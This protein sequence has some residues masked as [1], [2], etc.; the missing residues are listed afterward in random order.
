MV[1]GVGALPRRHVQSLETMLV[2][3]QQRDA[4]SDDY[5]AYYAILSRPGCSAAKLV[6]DSLAAVWAG[7]MTAKVAGERELTYGVLAALARR[8]LSSRG[9]TSPANSPAPRRAWLR[10][11]LLLTTAPAMMAG[12]WVRGR[13]RAGLRRHGRR[14]AAGALHAVSPAPHDRV[15]GRAGRLQ[16]SGRAGVGRTRHAHAAVQGVRR[17]VRG[18]GRRGGPTTASCRWRTRSAAPSTATTTCCSSTTCRSPARWRFRG[19]LPAGAA[20]HAASR[21]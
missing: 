14:T 7:Y 21:T 9:S 16:R 4:A 6:F 5:A 12:A 13:A 10:A 1:V 17:R 20:R 15:P 19:A 8:P 11:G 2:G 3:T 18:R